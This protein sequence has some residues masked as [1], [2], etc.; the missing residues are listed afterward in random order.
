MTETK[1]GLNNESHPSLPGDG[2]VVMDFY[3]VKAF[4]DWDISDF[5]FAHAESLADQPLRRDHIPFY[6]FNKV[7]EGEHRL[8]FSKCQPTS[9]LA[10]VL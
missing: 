9:N 3:K 6:G 7:P 5:D 8:Q 4:K 10:D 2:R 1:K